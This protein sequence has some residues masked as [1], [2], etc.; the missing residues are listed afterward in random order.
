METV[1][2]TA[3]ALIFFIILTISG[4]FRA[5]ARKSG[6]QIRRKEE[7]IAALTFRMILAMPLLFAFLS[8]IFYPD[9]ITPF[10][11]ELPDY[12]RFSGVALGI[13][14]VPFVYRVFTNIGR[15]ISETI[16]TK[17]NQE[18]VMTGP[19]Q[20]IRHPLYTG[21]LIEFF[22]LGIISANGL[23]LFSSLLTALIFRLIIIP[24]EEKNLKKIF[25]N[26][27][28]KYMKKTGAMFP[29]IF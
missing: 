26:R 3:F 12:I 22:S 13:L 2:R 17:K 25:G 21:A 29:K 28:E 10:S 4:Y 8:Y 18:L 15:N 24:L 7:G 1:F 27:Y 16:L 23:I 9:L 14:C 6:G 5:R 20:Y 19:Y 11:F